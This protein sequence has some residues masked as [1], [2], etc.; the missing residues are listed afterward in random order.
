MD[1]YDLGNELLYLL[2][3]E[4]KRQVSKSTPHFK[5]L[6]D[7]SLQFEY[8]RWSECNLPCNVL[9]IKEKS[10]QSRKVGFFH[11]LGPMLHNEDI[12]YAVTHSQNSLDPDINSLFGSELCNSLYV[13]PEY[14]E[15]SGFITG[16][17]PAL[18]GVSLALA[19]ILLEE[20][21]SQ[22]F[23]ISNVN[24]PAQKMLKKYGFELKEYESMIDAIY[25]LPGDI[26]PI[27]IKNN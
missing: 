6:S 8:Q 14:R 1:P 2:K 19:D 22:V 20:D 21:I 24:K 12:R 3:T 9:M 13:T 16:I 11:F 25:L 26:N 15:S 10:R 23:L 4:K 17:A 5:E 18:I 27:Q 7:I